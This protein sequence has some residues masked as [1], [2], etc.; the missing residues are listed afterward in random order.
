MDLDLIFV[1]GLFLAVF[2]IPGL[3]NAYS[4][5]RWPR[6]A[7]LMLIGGIVM[8]GYSVR[9]APEEYT[10]DTVDDVIVRVVATYF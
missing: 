3:V 10:L 6:L 8:L 2:S 1:G 9:E 5:R 4:D 7:A